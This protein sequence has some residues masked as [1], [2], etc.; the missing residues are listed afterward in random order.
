MENHDL[1]PTIFK[2]LRNLDST[3]NL[4]HFSRPSKVH[5]FNLK[6]QNVKH[7][8][9]NWQP[10]FPIS[11]ILTSSSSALP[12]PRWAS[13]FGHM[14][15]MRHE[16]CNSS[17]MPVWSRIAIFWHRVNKFPCHLLLVVFK[18]IMNSTPLLVKHIWFFQTRTF[19]LVV[20]FFPTF[21]SKSMMARRAHKSTASLV[22]V[23]QGARSELRIYYIYKR[24]CCLK[25]KIQG[26]WPPTWISFQ[27]PSPDSISFPGT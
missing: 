3:A 12:W 9:I 13:S 4:G 15:S 10:R 14:W 19:C 23:W 11:H 17:T 26:F 7:P 6:P 18:V 5:G 24:W 1:S 20:A 8:K 2:M 22:T 16:I 21:L 25:N 27:R